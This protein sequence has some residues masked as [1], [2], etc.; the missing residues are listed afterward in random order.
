[1]I[2]HSGATDVNVSEHDLFENK[3][4]SDPEIPPMIRHSGATDVNVSE[5]DLFEN[6]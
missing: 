3:N 4:T 2:R 1:M 5:Q 6:S